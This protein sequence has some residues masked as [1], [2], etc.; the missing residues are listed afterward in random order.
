[1]VVRATRFVVPS[2]VGDLPY[3]NEEMIK[4]EGF[5]KD[6]KQTNYIETKNI[7]TKLSNEQIAEGIKKYAK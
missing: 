2:V 4:V 1:M 7:E 5:G 3:T 6:N